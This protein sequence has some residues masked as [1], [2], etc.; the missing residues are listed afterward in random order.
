MRQGSNERGGLPDRRALRE[1][2]E[3]IAAVRAGGKDKSLG[4]EEFLARLEAD[5]TP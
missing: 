2:Q 4:I 3:D 1:D 5:G